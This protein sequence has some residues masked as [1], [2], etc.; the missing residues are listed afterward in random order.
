MRCGTLFVQKNKVWIWKAYCRTTG[1]LIDWELGD[2]SSETLW[3]LTARLAEYDVT[4]YYTD[5]YEGYAELIPPELLTQTKT[6]THGIE[7]N[8]GQQR[9]WFARF[10]RRTC[11]VSHSIAMIDLTIALFAWFHS[12]SGKHRLFDLRFIT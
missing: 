1:E 4:I 9:H 12:K 2:R 3:K 7:R 6:E 10:R 8:N 11:V 5:R